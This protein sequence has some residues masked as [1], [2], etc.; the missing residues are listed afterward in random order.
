[1]T[2][3]LVTVALIGSCG[4]GAVVYGSYRTSNT[5]RWKDDGQSRVYELGGDKFEE[6]ARLKR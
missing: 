3:R 4:I 2:T 5:A 1:M 6:T